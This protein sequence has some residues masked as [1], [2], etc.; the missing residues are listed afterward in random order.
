MMTPKNCRGSWEN[1][2]YMTYTSVDWN[3]QSECG[4]PVSWIRSY[5]EEWEDQMQSLPRKQ[6]ATWWLWLCCG[7]K[8]SCSEKNQQP[9][10]AMGPLTV[11]PPLLLGTLSPSGH[12]WPR[13]PGCLLGQRNHHVHTA[14]H[15]SQHHHMWKCRLPRIKQTIKPMML[16]I[17]AF[18]YLAPVFSEFPSTYRVK[19]FR[20]L[21]LISPSTTH[22]RIPFIPLGKR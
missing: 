1:V 22:C 21:K 20:S 18:I 10:E 3:I 2:S 12:Q 5:G 17:M 15:F 13:S 9:A 7:L 19:N 16:G 14:E 11:T 4:L 8:Q 6:G